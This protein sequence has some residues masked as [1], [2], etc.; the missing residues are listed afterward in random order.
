MRTQNDYKYI[1]SEAN[2]NIQRL[3]GTPQELPALTRMR[4]W[5][6]VGMA[7]LVDNSPKG[8]SDMLLKGMDMADKGMHESAKKYPHAE[9]AAHE[10]ADRLLELQ[11][12][13]RSVYRKYLN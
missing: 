7:A 4:T 3:G 2:E 11:V 9:R 6:M 5:S 8:M 10:L 1:A 13:Q 12:G